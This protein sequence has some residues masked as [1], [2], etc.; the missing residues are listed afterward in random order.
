M[1]SKILFTLEVVAL[2]AAPFGYLKLRDYRAEQF[3][4]KGNAA[5]LKGDWDQAYACYQEAARRD[6]KVVKASVACRLTLCK[7][8]GLGVAP[9]ERLEMCPRHG[10]TFADCL[11]ASRVPT[12]KVL[13]AT[14]QSLFESGSTAVIVWGASTYRKGSFS[15]QQ[16]YAEA[17]AWYRVAAARGNVSAQSKLVG[18]AYDYKNRWWSPK[19]NEFPSEWLLNVE[20][21][22]SGSH[23]LLHEYI[24]ARLFL[25][26]RIAAGDETL[27]QHPEATDWLS[28]AAMVG[29][30]DAQ[31]I[32][33]IKLAEGATLDLPEETATDYVLAAAKQGNEKAK[34]RIVEL[35]QQGIYR[36]SRWDSLPTEWLLA[37]AKQGNEKAQIRIVELIQLGLYTDSTWDNLP[38]AWLIAAAQNNNEAAQ[39]HLG[40]KLAEG[41]PLD[42]PEET[43]I[44]CLLTAAQQDNEKAQ[45]LL[46][47][48]LAEGESLPISQET[49]TVY[50]LVAAKQGNVLAQG[51]IVNKVLGR[52]CT[53]ELEQEA[54]PFLLSEAKNGNSAVQAYLGA[55]CAEGKPLPIPSKTANAYL[56]LA[57][58]Q[59]NEKAQVRIVDLVQF[60]L[61]TDASWKDLPVE[62]LL[63]AAKQGNEKAKEQ[64]IENVFVGHYSAKTEQK[65]LPILLSAAKSGNERVRVYLGNKLA[66]GATLNL[67]EETVAD[68]L[69]LVAKQGNEKAKDALS[70]AAKQGNTMAKDALAQMFEE[71]RW[72]E[73]TNEEKFRA[74]LPYAEAGIAEAQRR[75][76][77]YYWYG[78]GVPQS[79][80]TAREWYRKAAVN[81]DAYAQWWVDW[82]D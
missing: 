81:G 52:K 51:R 67:P 54:I 39:V 12:T 11:E 46:G 30:E 73:G 4:D 10:S 33:G 75:L 47:T 9:T 15:V 57:A 18:L 20:S 16:D 5:L 76:A 1:F 7:D 70:A 72:K 45:L 61:Y 63:A 44:T 38:V 82:N 78:L 17:V 19:P 58:Q 2:I 23:V 53:P 77:E 31:A 69:F 34:V 27:A 6:N 26:E 74:L 13:E 8:F 36:D 43:A 48:R 29:N 42:L 65:V 35:A 14:K 79:A 56:L 66:E 40:A 71:G 62:W 28:E 24:A 64:L 21:T 60:G 32:L 68:C 80:E 3:F 49:A 37:A 50:L 25:G 55:L 59:G 41:A 22:P